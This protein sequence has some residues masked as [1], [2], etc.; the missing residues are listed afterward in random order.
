MHVSPAQSTLLQ[1][2]MIQHGWPRGA[3]C[4]DAPAPMT[5][6]AFVGRGLRVLS[7]TCSTLLTASYSVEQLVDLSLSS[8]VHDAFSTYLG[9]GSCTRTPG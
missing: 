9:S 5:K 3:H 1:A 8:S 7:L 4:T 2:S 6:S